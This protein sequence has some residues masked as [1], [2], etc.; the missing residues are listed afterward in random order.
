MKT[1]SNE[2]YDEALNNPDYQKIINSILSQF[3]FSYDDKKECKLIGLWEALRLY[4][5]DKDCEFT[6]YLYYHIWWQCVSKLKKSEKTLS[7][8]SSIESC[9]SFNLSEYVPEFYLKFLQDKVLG[10]YSLN[11]LQ[12]KY[13]MPKRALRQIFQRIK[14]YINL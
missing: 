9:P 5:P 2:E 11:E 14:Y 4:S 1:I 13:K 10:Q 8:L 3:N 12:V 7:S 6:T